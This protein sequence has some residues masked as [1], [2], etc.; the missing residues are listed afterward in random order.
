MKELFECYSNLIEKAPQGSLKNEAAAKWHRVYEELLPEQKE[1]I[2]AFRAE[3]WQ[4]F[5][6]ETED[7][8]KRIIAAGFSSFEKSTLVSQ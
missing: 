5:L 6:K 1:E 2:K 3:R 4:I 8:D 7:L